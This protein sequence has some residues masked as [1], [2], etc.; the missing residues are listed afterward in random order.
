MSKI[1]AH[2]VSVLTIE[3]VLESRFSPTY[4]IRTNSATLY[5]NPCI[6]WWAPFVSD[7][8]TFLVGVAVREVFSTAS[9]IS[10]QGLVRR[11][12]F[13]TVDHKGFYLVLPC[14]QF[15]PKLFPQG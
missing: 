7:Y 11:G 15:Q 6:Y 13:D 14:F 4:E 3:Q 12:P 8:R 1:H 10:L 5:S 9:R 2:T